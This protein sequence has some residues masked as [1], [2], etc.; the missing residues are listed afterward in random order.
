VAVHGK[1]TKV[2]FN[3]F[4]FTSFFN[5][6]SVPME[7]SMT[8]TTAFGA[9]S[10]T[11][12]P[13]HNNATISAEGFYDGSANSVDEKLAEAFAVDSKLWSVYL[14]GDAFGSPGYAMSAI[15][16]AYN[17][18]STIDDACRISAAAQSNKTGTERVISLHAHAA[19][20]AAWT[21]TTLNNGAA[22]EAGGSTY[23]H[24]TA[25]TG[26]VEIS[27]RHST[28]NFVADDTELVAFTPVTEAVAERKTFTGAVKQYVRG[29]ATIAGGETI[30]FQLGFYRA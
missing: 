22:S 30:T 27:I 13:G 29:I 12:M 16:N 19:E 6:A 28:D 14:S 23:L 9:N 7:A 8:D 11:Y 2:F 20:T 4:N 1:N 24:V 21:G 3:E 15:E 18:M 17:V 5:S 26:T 25:A 10:K